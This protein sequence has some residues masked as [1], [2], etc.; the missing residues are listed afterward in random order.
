MVAPHIQDMA[1]KK[2]GF[3][4]DMH[5]QK[6]DQ[7]IGVGGGDPKKNLLFVRNLLLMLSPETTKS[8]KNSLQQYEFSASFQGCF[9]LH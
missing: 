4:G 6:R 5:V 7:G 2:R 1:H 3:G 8:G 9:T